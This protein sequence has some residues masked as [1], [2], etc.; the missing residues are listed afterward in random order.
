[1]DGNALYSNGCQFDNIEPLPP[2]CGAPLGI[3]QFKEPQ[4]DS[5]EAT[6][7]ET[8]AKRAIDDADCWKQ[9]LLRV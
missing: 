3:P 2:L 8:F 6:D 9:I 1:M 4:T 7:S 5:S